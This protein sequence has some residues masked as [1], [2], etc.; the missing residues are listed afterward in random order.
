MR[1][2]L[3]RL[4]ALEAGDGYPRAEVE[5]L[6]A[7]DAS[8]GIAAVDGRPAARAT[9]VSLVARAW[10]VRATGEPPE[11]DTGDVRAEDVIAV[12]ETGGA[13]D[14]RASA[15]RESDAL[16]A[17]GHRLGRELADKLTRATAS[18]P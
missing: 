4:G 8:E 10:I 3:A 15:F 9:D 5:V 2:E 7:D 18:P 16:R 14:L 1:E 13:L 12:D 17:S 11:S 6:L